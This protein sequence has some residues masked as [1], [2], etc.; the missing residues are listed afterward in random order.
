LL[1]TLWS[2]LIAKAYLFTLG[3]SLL[4]LCCFAYFICSFLP[5]GTKIVDVFIRFHMKIFSFCGT[6]IQR[7]LR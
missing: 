4:Q 6:A 3:F 1:G 2:A 7:A 5:G